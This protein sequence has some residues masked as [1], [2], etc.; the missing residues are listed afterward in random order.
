MKNVKMM[1]A[2]FSRR[3]TG[4]AIG[5]PSHD[6]RATTSAEYAAANAKVTSARDARVTTRPPRQA[7]RKPKYAALP[8]WPGETQ[9]RSVQT[10]SRTSAM[11]VGLNR[12]LPRTRSTN[13]LP[14]AIVAAA[15]ATQ[16]SFVRR[17]RHNDRA[18]INAL[19]GSHLAARGESPASYRDGRGARLARRDDREP[20]PPPR[21]F[22]AVG[23]Q[24]REYLREEQRSQP[25]GPPTRQPRWGG[26]GMH[27]PS[28]AAGL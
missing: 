16:R 27:R 17:S 3:W 11:L 7:T 13:L 15:A 20:G 9:T 4:M 19:R 10:M 8:H 23:W 14:I 6:E 28:N 1:S 12:C 22:C 21:V 18:E 25:R 5:S 26:A 24:Y 2:P